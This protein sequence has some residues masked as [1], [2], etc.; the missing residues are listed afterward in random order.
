MAHFC[1]CRNVPDFLFQY[2]INALSALLNTY[3]S[4]W[5]VFDKREAQIKEEETELK[6][7]K[8]VI[9]ESKELTLND[10][11]TAKPSIH[12]DSGRRVQPLV[13]LSN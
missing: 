5:I 7:L 1:I 9:T 8:R 6:R 11:L 4:H 10:R 13:S 3:Y 12:F 2:M